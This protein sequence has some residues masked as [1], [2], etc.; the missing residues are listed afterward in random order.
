MSAPPPKPAVSIVVPAWGTYAGAQ[1]Q[2]ALA[3]I[4]RQD[5]SPQVIVVDNAN[6]PPLAL[7]GDV[8][9]VRSER[10]LTVGSARNLGIASAT[11]DLLVMWD[12]DDV[13]PDGVLR[14]L[15]TTMRESPDRIAH[16]LAIHEAPGGARHRWPRPLALRLRAHRRLFALLNCI[17]STYPTTGATVMRTAVVRS[18]GGYADSDSGDDWVLGASLLLRGGVGWSE[19]PGRLYSNS[20]TS[21]WARHHSLRHLLVHSRQVRR[22]IAA[23]ADLLGPLRPLAPLLGPLQWVVLFGIVLPV[24]A[25]RRVRAAY[26][27]L[28]GRSRAASV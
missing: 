13:M 17:W 19:L 15:V 12:A 2:R 26:R 20:P 9:V 16:A 6:D 27:S 25:Q 5:E 11:G 28:R 10:R 1:L 23:D 24:R 22:R 14:T 21:I 7:D 18:C 4:A 3:S 8:E